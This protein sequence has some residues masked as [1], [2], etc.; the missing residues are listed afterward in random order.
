[1]RTCFT[2]LTTLLIGFLFINTAT[3]NVFISQ[4][5]GNFNDAGTWNV[6]G[7]QIPGETD[8]VIIK[9]EVDIYLNSK[10]KKG[11]N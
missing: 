1:M 4:S 3:A 5:N 2:F 10:K 8:D 7:G 6:G 9:H 11:T